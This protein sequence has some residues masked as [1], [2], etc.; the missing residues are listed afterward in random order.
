MWSRLFVIG[1]GVGLAACGQDAPPDAGKSAV[2]TGHASA[3]AGD[4]ARAAFPCCGDPATT[5][6]VQGTIALGARLAADDAAGAGAAAAAL[7]PLFAAAPALAGASAPLQA[8]QGASDLAAQQSAFVAVA[9]PVVAVAQ[10]AGPGPLQIAVV[11]CPMKP[12][13]W[14]QDQE[15]VAN[16]FYGAR[17]LT[18]GGF[19]APG[20]AR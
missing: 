20:A 14:L 2:I 19:V 15:P 6:A 8:L 11:H 3:A 7:G 5:A 17:M 12:G 13:S 10:S 9:A 16:P 4:F 1:W 18:C